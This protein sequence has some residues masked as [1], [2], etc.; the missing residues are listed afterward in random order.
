MTERVLAV[1]AHP[2]DIEF[3]MAGTLLRLRQA[4][5]ELHYMNVADGCCG[6]TR[7]DRA[8]TAQIRRQEA[9]TAAARLGAVYHESLCHDLEIFYDLDTLQ[10]LTSVV[11]QV[12]PR[13]LLTHAPSDY[14]EDHANTARLAVTA[15]FARGMPNF[16][17]HPL[18]APVLQP[19]TVYHAQPYG[20][21]DPLR[22]LVTPDLFV[23]ITDVQTIKVEAWLSTR[24]KSCG[25]MKV[26]GWTRTCKRCGT[27]TP[28]SGGCPG[29]SR[30]PKVG[31]AACTWVSAPCTTIPSAK[32]WPATS[33]IGRVDRN[34]RSVERLCAFAPPRENLAETAGQGALAPLD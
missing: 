25:W 2:D 27:W 16:H 18:S 22:H 5:Y 19:I 31:A 12:A 26:R 13:I 23:D 34:S 17:V 9:Q 28:K 10:R 1:A 4:G 33:A 14:M 7:T 8:A 29:V 6:S 21:H 32:R 20:N 3:L 24:A 11:R 30:S 15:A